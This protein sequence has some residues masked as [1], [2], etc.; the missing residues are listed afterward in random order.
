M[1]VKTLWWGAAVLASA[2]LA[3]SRGAADPPPGELAQTEA[4]IVRCDDGSRQPQED[5]AVCAR[6]I[7]RLWELLQQGTA[8]YLNAHPKASAREVQADLAI[9]VKEDDQTPSAVRLGGDAVVVSAMWG[10]YGD[11]FIVSRAPGEP[12]AVTWDLRALAAKGPPDGELA[13]WSY[14][15]PGVH[16]GPLGGVVL[17]LA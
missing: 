1:P 3:P 2:L 14:A 12:Y 15:D 4:Q 13:A 9:R 16:S 10:F 11:A 5:A 7:G 8:A 6:A 17:G